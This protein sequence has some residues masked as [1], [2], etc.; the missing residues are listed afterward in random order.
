MVIDCDVLIEVL[1]EIG[2]IHALKCIKR[3]AKISIALNPKLF[4]SKDLILANFDSQGEEGRIIESDVEIIPIDKRV[5][6][7]VEDAL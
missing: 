7:G 1:Q 3:F 5:H 6:I 4:E 2:I